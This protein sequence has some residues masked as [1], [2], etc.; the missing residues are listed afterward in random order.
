MPAELIKNIPASTKASWKSYAK[1]KFIGHS[2]R[3]ILEEGIRKTEL[4]LKYKHLKK[5]PCTIETIYISLAE[6][7]DFVKIPLYR[8]KENKEKILDIIQLYQSV[9]PL[10]KLLNY[11]KISRSTYQNWILDIK[12]QCVSS[13]YQVCVRKYGTQLL[14]TQVE[15]IKETLL[16]DDY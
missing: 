12:I 14:K 11:F 4:Y 15:L 13:Y 6:M 3:T 2:Q 8:L 1:E 9:I 7:I 16:S 10:D 5:V